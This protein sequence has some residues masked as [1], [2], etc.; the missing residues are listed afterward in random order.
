MICEKISGVKFV[1]EKIQCVYHLFSSLVSNET[2]NHLKHKGN[3]IYHL[4][5]HLKILHFPHRLCL[6]LAR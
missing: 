1:Q 6:C 2:I 5:Y 4:L 3:Y